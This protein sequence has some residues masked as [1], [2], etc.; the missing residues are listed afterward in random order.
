MIVTTEMLYQLLQTLCSQ[1]ENLSGWEKPIYFSPAVFLLTKSDLECVIVYSV[2][3][4][5]FSLVFLVDFLLFVMYFD[6]DLHNK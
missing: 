6:C 5:Y 1:C 4:S 3:A 2:H